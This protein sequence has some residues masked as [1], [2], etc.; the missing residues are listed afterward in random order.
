MEIYAFGQGLP[1]VCVPVPSSMHH[2]LGPAPACG[3]F[4]LDGL[5]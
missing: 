4:L 2:H 1:I 3:A 5:V